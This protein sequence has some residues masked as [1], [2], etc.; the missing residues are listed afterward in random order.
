MCGMQ[1]DDVGTTPGSCSLPLPGYDMRVLNEAGEEVG[2]GEMGTIALKLP[3]PPGFMS[4]LWENDERFNEI[5]MTEF[6]GYYSAMDAGFCDEV[7]C[8]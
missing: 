2:C 7:G 5:Y 4:T 3:L 8:L 6:P 1:L